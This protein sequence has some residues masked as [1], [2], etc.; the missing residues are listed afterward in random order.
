MSSISDLSSQLIAIVRERQHVALRLYANSDPALDAL[1]RELNVFT[2]I[3]NAPQYHPGQ[4]A[5]RSLLASFDITGPYG[6]Q[7]RCLVHPPL[8]DSAIGIRRRNEIRKLPKPVVALI[9]KRLFSA[10]ELLHDECHVAHTD[11]RESDILLGAADSFF[12]QFQNDELKWPSPAKEVAGGGIIYLSRQMGIPRDVGA[13][14]LC[15][16]GSAVPLD[17]GVEHYEDIQPNTYRAPE[18]I[19]QIPWTY[20]VDIWNVG[21]LVSTDRNTITYTRS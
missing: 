8:W 6:V 7:H 19:L 10:L 4:S 14:F 21:C 12:E 3:E 20:S 9:L 1:T 16:F 15:D 17:D 5:V 13:P 11:I 18:V 2:R